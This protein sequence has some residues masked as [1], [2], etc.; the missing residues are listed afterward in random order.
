MNFLA[1]NY[2]QYMLPCLSKKF[3]GIE[4][5][6]CGM[7]RSLVLL[8]QGDFSAAFHMYPA[9]FT[10]VLL[11]GV[12][13]FNAIRNFKYAGKLIYFLAILNAV[14]IVTGYFYKHFN[15]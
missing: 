9:I 11:F 10:L 5:F 1:T 2:E 12:I 13:G 3:F 4:C 6:G 15:F 14:I 8:I 7:Q